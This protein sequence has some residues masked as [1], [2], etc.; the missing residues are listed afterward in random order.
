M[1]ID[2]LLAV[3]FFIPDLLWSLIPVISMSQTMVYSELYAFMW[4]VGYL[5]PIGALIPLI[6]IIIYLEISAAFMATVLR[7][8][9]FIPF[10]GGS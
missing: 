2:L 1:L 3:V 5:F 8:K 10:M 9:S 7:F 6:M 4:V